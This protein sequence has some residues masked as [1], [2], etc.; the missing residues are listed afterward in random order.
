ME[1]IINPIEPP[2]NAIAAI[3][4]RGIGAKASNKI[5]RLSSPKLAN[6]ITLIYS[7]LHR[8]NEA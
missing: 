4:A 7:F 2:E 1:P 8:G 3:A 6:S 5:S